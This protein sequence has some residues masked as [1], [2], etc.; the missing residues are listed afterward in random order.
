MEGAEAATEVLIDYALQ[1]RREGMLGRLCTVWGAVKPPD[2]TQW[3]PI[4]A[5]MS[6]MQGA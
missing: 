4:Q 3:P 5:A 1:H 6:R 2:L